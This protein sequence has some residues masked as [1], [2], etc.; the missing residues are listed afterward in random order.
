MD[1]PLLASFVGWLTSINRSAA[2]MC[3]KRRLEG[4]FWWLL[5]S[6][7]DLLCEEGIQ[8]CA[9]ILWLSIRRALTQY[10]LNCLQ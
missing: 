5:T 4:V 9:R 10:P 8:V 2:H 1:C 7:S 6:V 3:A